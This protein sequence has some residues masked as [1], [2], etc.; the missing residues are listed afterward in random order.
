MQEWV[1]VQPKSFYFD[2]NKKLVDQLPTL[3]R[4]AII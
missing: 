1:N 3:K 4:E 2:G